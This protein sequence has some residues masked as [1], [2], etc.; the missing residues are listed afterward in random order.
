[1]KH[2]IL[3]VLLVCLG[4]FGTAQARHLTGRVLDAKTKESM[5]GVTVELLNATDSSLIRSTA[6]A[7]R[8]F[9]GMKITGYQI[10]VENNTTYL[11][12]FSMI[13]FKPVY[14]RVEVKMA[15]RVNEQYVEDVS[16]EEDSKVLDEVVVKATKIKMVMKG[17]TLV[18]DASAFNLSQGS[19][20]DA[21][22]RQMPGTTLENGVIKVNGRTVSSLLVD[23]RDFFKG[24]AKKALENLPAY[25]VDKVKAYD[26]QGKDS[27]FMGRNMN[28]KEFVLDVSLKKEYQHGMMANVDLAGGTDH[29]Y[30]SKLFSMLY[31][32]RS[33]LTLFGSMNNI[34]DRGVPGEGDSGDFSSDVTGGLTATK[35]GGLSYR[36]EGKSEDDFFESGLSMAYTDNETVMQTTSQT[37]LT[38]GDYYGLNRNGNWAKNTTWT[39]GNTFG[40]N[41]G[42]HLLDGRLNVSRTKNNGWGSNLDGRFGARPRDFSQL[43]SLFMPDAGRRLL[44]MAINRVRNDNKHNG[45]NTSLDVSMGD[46]LRFGTDEDWENMMHVNG[47]FRYSRGKDYRFARNQIDYLANNPSEDHRNQYSESP[48]EDYSLTLFADYTRVIKCDSDDVNSIML[49]PYYNFNKTYNSSD[50]SLHRLDLLQDYTDEAYSLGVLPSTRD[51]LLSVLDA[52]NSFRSREHTTLHQAGVT[53]HFMHGDGRRMP[54]LSAAISLPIDVRREKLDYYRGQNHSMSRTSLLFD[55]NVTV[56][57]QFND[58]TGSRYASLTYNTRQSQPSLFSLLDIRDD[59]NPLVITL[60][61]PNLKK[62]RAHSLYFNGMIFS[63]G[64]QRFISVTTS[65]SITQNAIA[66]SM[67]YDK[68]TGKTTTQQVNVNGNWNLGG[69]LNFGGPIDKQ[70]RLTLQQTLGL[71]YNNSVDLTT[72]EGTQAVRSDVHNWNAN[73]MLNLQYQLGE[74]LRVNVKGHAAYQRA[75]SP[76]VGFQTVSAWNFSVGTGGTVQLPWAFEFSTDLVDYIRRGY[77]DPQMNTSELVWNARLSKKMLEDKLV[78]SL[79]GFDILGNLS[80]TA[81]T[82]NSQGRTETWTNTL[83]RYLMLR[84]SYKFNLGMKRPTSGG[85]VMYGGEM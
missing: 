22:V 78:L 20:L 40:L 74:K 73:G 25:T 77:N 62:A 48:S 4:C 68:A 85:G 32:K 80:N 76:R 35:M 53:A 67:L 38:G 36:Y 81:L 55:P 79:D 57:Y 28:D 82:L 17:D 2:K 26:K 63:M 12:R 75:T 43:D 31:T 72:V 60:G 70:K 11:L 24:D 59:A 33:R 52:R 6:T 56:F 44:A 21:L 37:F 41:P 9:F 66:T 34:N 69:N 30:G 18:Y 42:N 5:V 71:N 54:H 83:N 15:D 51:A 7:E 46:R 3:M 47:D 29:R 84:V 1:M 65:F 10:D 23:G 19:M 16:L 27:R 39:W 45:E 58:S 64:T 50:Y 8:E 49:R 14:K 13:G 61:N